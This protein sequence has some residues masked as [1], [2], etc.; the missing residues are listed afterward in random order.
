MLDYLR[1][2]PTAYRSEV[3]QF[4]F[5]KFEVVISKQRISEI[6]GERHFSKKAAQRIAAEQNLLLRADYEEKIKSMPAYRICCVDKSTSNERTGQRKYSF[7]LL[8]IPC[9]DQGS[10]K[11]SKRI[12]VLLA[13]TVDGYL[14]NPLI[15]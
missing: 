6:L 11:R 1:D 5:N 14:R 13:I 3:Q 7:L 10:T 12:S 2:R 9:K 8:N 4:L 15:Y